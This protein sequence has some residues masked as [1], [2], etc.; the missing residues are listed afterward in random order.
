MEASFVLTTML[1][2][3]WIT[4]KRCLEHV[5]VALLVPTWGWRGGGR[6]LV[7]LPGWVDVL[8]FLSFFQAFPYWQVPNRLYNW[9]A[10]SVVHN[11]ISIRPSNISSSRQ[12]TS[13]G[14]QNSLQSSALLTRGSKRFWTNLF[15]K[16][17]FSELAAGSYTIH[18]L[19]CPGASRQA[20]IIAGPTSCGIISWISKQWG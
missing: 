20:T 8:C 5:L 19:L 13:T 15:D 6:L 7:W 18:S 11:L 14:W 1:L 3:Y 9:Y 12:C 10:K 17:F 4:R 16:L 2:F